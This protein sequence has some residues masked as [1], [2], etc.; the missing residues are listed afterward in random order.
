MGGRGEKE[1]RKKTEVR[2]NQKQGGK[3]KSTG[4]NATE[5]KTGDRSNKK[6]R[7]DEI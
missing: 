1:Q 7:G 4:R 6:F 3:E 5:K 2:R